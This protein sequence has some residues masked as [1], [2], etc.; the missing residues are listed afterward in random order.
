M[1]QPNQLWSRR[2]DSE[3]E[4]VRATRGIW[5]DILNGVEVVIEKGR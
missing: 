2:I 4:F 3:S 1:A 5:D